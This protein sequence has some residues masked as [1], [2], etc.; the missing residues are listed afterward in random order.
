ME[1]AYLEEVV[2]HLP[3]DIHTRAHTHTHT[4]TYTHADTH[5]NTHTYTDRWAGRRGTAEI[6]HNHDLVIGTSQIGLLPCI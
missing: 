6:T 3:A 4:H 2:A 1:M 5:S